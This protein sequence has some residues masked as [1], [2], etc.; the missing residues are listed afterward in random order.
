[1]RMNWKPYLRLLRVPN[2]RGYFLMASFGFLIAKGFLFSFKDIIIFYAIILLFLAFGFS[3]NDC[4]DTKEDEYKKDSVN[5]IVKKEIIFKKAL[6]LSILLGILGLTLSA[7][8]GLKVLLFSLA[9]VLLSFFYSAPPLRTKSRPLIDLI[10][11]GLFAGA[12]LFFLPLLIFNSELTLFHYLIT[13]SIFYFSITL[14]LRNHLEDYETDKKAGLRTFVC[15]V[16]F[17]GSEKLLR[18]LAIFYPLTLFPIFLLIPQGYLF[19]FFFLTLVFLF[20]LLFRKTL[21]IVKNYKVMDVYAILSFSSL[22]LA[23]ILF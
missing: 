1:M 9:G 5:P 11:H 20:F 4:F 6:F 22:S 21:K 2:W 17:E 14:E 10:S 7:V 3:V 15:V 13:F 18:Y 8:F 16:G 19:F 12:F 23:T